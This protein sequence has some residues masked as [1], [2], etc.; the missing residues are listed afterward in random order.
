VLEELKSVIFISALA[1]PSYPTM[2]AIAQQVLSTN[3]Q[4]KHTTKGYVA[5]GEDSV[6]EQSFMMLFKCLL[7]AS[8]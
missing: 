7:Y 4:Y 3:K 1:K 5:K 2:D 6:V 8:I